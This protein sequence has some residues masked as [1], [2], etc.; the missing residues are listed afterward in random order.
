MPVTQPSRGG[1]NVIGKVRSVLPTL[2]S[3]RR[4][5]AFRPGRAGSIYVET[6]GAFLEPM[7]VER[8]LA[9]GYEPGTTAAPEVDEGERCCPGPGHGFKRAFQH[10]PHC[11]HPLR[12]R[13]SHVGAQ[14]TQTP[15]HAKG[16]GAHF[17]DR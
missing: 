3:Y 6:Q 9:M 10:F 2:M 16:E 13:L 15:A 11:I 12:N 7:A 1:H 14:R 5:R 8:E 4:S 17:Q